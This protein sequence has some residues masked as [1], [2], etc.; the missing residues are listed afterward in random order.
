MYAI[1]KTGGKQYR[2]SPGETL[3]VESLAVAE[4]E[5]INF[6]QVLMVADG[7]NISVGN[8]LLSDAVVTGKVLSHGRG[9]K[10]RIIKFRRRKHHRKQMGHRQNFTELE[11]VS[12]N[13]VTAP[14]GS[15]DNAKGAKAKSDSGKDKKSGA[16][17]DS[18]SGAKAAAGAAAVTAAAGATA[19]ASAS[20]DSASTEA[21][22][23][24]D[25]PNGEPDDL[26]KILGIGPVLEEKLNGMG[27]Y[28]YSQIAAFT[29]DDIASINTHLNFPGRIERD[30][31]IPQA[32]ELMQGGEGRKLKYLDG[33]DGEPDDLKQISGVG[34]VLEGKLNELGI[35]HFWQIAKFEQRDI[36]L[37]NDATAFP[38]RIER[39][40][41]IDQAKVLAD[42]GEPR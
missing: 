10:V 22:H 32:A 5:S 8:P 42:G 37:V 38:G 17:D 14:A 28:H 26:K 19:A 3:R 13:G 12:I 41:W 7:D 27:I 35:Y 1:I 2:V 23:F 33:P 34:P 18:G 30:E 39:D 11:I 25:A 16:N 9:D 40:E 6:D 36:D 24:L 21:P 29:D 31:W 15:E 20:A 4:G